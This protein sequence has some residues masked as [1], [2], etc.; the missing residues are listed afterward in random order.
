[1]RLPLPPAPI[2]SPT[3]HTA[4][5]AWLNHLAI[6]NTADGHRTEFD[7]PANLQSIAFD[8]SDAGAALAT[9]DSLA[10]LPLSALAWPEEGTT[11]LPA[12]AYRMVLGP[13]RIATVARSGE[14]TLALY[15]YTLADGQI[16]P[17]GSGEGRDLGATAAYRLHLDDQRGRVLLG[18]VKG[19]HALSGEGTP[20]DGLM[21]ISA[22]YRLL[23]KGDGLPFAPHAHLYPLADGSAAFTERHRLVTM[24]LENPQQ[25]RVARI[26]DWPTP[27]E[28]V[29]L[30]PDGRYLAWMWSGSGFNMH[31]QAA[32]I[33]YSQPILDHQFWLDG[34]FPALAVDNAGVVTIAWGTRPHWLN[35]LRVAPDLEPVTLQVVAP[36]E[37]D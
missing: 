14:R 35:L 37:P 12:P 25:P 2:L 3:G 18:G 30:S 24:S 32:L 22:D 10:W 13:T 19:R 1:M 34:L 15:G 7:A 11:N 26:Q 21:E 36:A 31:V 6:V 8:G 16:A 9:G 28:T 23:W 5:A 4:A 17:I 20:F 27:L 33:D 29:A